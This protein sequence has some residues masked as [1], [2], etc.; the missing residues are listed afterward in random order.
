MSEIPRV[1]ER[2]YRTTVEPQPARSGRSR[3][4]DADDRSRRSV[5]RCDARHE[6]RRCKQMRIDVADSLAAQVAS[7]AMKRSTS[8]CARD[9][10]RG[11]RGQKTRAFLSAVSACPTPTHRHE[12]MHQHFGSFIEQ[13]AQPIVVVCADGRSR[14]RYRRGPSPILARAVRRRAGA[15]AAASFRRVW[16]GA[17]TVSRSISARRLCR[18]NAV[19]SFTPVSCGA[20]SRRSSSMFNVVLICESPWHTK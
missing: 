8:A 7:I 3:A 15:F 4:N 10:R 17:G 6:H 2:I 9:G 13:F 11:I 19:F 18:T 16:R 20:R 14:P 1:R 12:R 5:S